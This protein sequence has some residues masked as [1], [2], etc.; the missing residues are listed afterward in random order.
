MGIAD[1]LRVLGAIEDLLQDSSNAG[2]PWHGKK[3]DLVYRL[4]GSDF[5][6][7]YVKG[8]SAALIVEFVEEIGLAVEADEEL[9]YRSE[10]E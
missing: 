2:Q 10:K 9:I 7:I 4:S 3:L 8:E 1:K 5:Y 6:E